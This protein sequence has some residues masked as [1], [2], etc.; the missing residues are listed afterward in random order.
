M[1]ISKLKHTERDTINPVRPSVSVYLFTQPPPS[2]LHAR[3]FHIP[4][5]DPSICEG[6]CQQQC[7]G[8]CSPWERG[9]V[10]RPT[11]TARRLLGVLTACEWRETDAFL[12]KGE[13]NEEGSRGF[14]DRG[15]EKE[16]GE[17]RV[18][19]HTTHEKILLWGYFDLEQAI[20]TFPS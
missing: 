11:K 12:H 15:K 16:Q 3:V 1:A 7:G 8:F 14:F 17:Q 2:L 6:I 20:I 9:S 19:V 18:C 10:S 5:G 4:P 13:V